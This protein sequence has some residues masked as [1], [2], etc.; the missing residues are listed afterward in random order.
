MSYYE[1]LKK[2]YDEI[3]LKFKKGLLDETEFSNMIEELECLMLDE[4]F[5]FGE[6]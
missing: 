4:E 5:V 1:E 6:E 3:I 2:Q